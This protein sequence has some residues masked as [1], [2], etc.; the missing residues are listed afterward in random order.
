MTVIWLFV[1]HWEIAPALLCLGLAIWLWAVRAHLFGILLLAIAEK[2]MKRRDYDRAFAV[3]TRLLREHGFPW[4]N[5]NNE[6]WQ[7]VRG[8][9]H[10]I[11]GTVYQRRGEDGIAAAEFDWAI[12]LAPDLEEA[13]LRQAATYRKIGHWS[14]LEDA[15]DNCDAVIGSF[16]ERPRHYMSRA[17]VFLLAGCDE[18][19]LA[20]CDQALALGT[21]KAHIYRQAGLVRLCAGR[22][23]EA[24]MAL[25]PAV[26]LSPQNAYGVLLLHLAR[27]GAGEDD[28]AELRAHAS[29]IDCTVWPGPLVQLYCGELAPDEAFAA[30]TRSETTAR[31]RR[32]E[33]AFYLGER[34]LL[35]GDIERAKPLLE[36]AKDACPASF[37]ECWAADSELR[38]VARR[39]HPHDCSEAGAALNYDKGPAVA[40]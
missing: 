18:E 36:E 13:Y 14:R 34:A 25:A 8:G 29:K 6:E 11:R 31:E 39:E 7:V 3:A 24:A 33:T 10:C 20:D 12:E 30:A 32:G 2:A 40:G 37:I 5:Q 38:R 4:P 27:R 35:A 22:Y 23:S 26:R 17:V 21:G 15:I 19:A 9:A 1:R 16:P 28:T